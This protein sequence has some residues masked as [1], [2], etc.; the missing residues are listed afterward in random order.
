MKDFKKMPKMACGGGVG[1]YE[2]G[3]KVTAADVSAR[4][5]KYQD[6]PNY[7][8]KEDDSPAGVRARE[9]YYKE[10]KKSGGSDRPDFMKA[11]ETDLKAREAGGKAARNVI[12]KDREQVKTMSNVDTMGNAMKKGGK[13]KRGNKK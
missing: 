12:A 4:L 11:T 1:K 2:T 10:Y 9:S 7:N 5:E 6:N 8:S 3:G 13:V